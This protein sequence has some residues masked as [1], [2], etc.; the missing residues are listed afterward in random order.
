MP[1]STE[2]TVAAV[3]GG[4][5]LRSGTGLVVGMLLRR[6]A[7][8]DDDARESEDDVEVLHRGGGGFHGYLL[9]VVSIN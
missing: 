3:I 8:K 1:N 4:S 2:V 6:G 7:G 5:V 9:S